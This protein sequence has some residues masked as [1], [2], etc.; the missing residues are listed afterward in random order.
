MI[1][2]VEI[3]NCLCDHDHAPFKGALS[4]LCLDLT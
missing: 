4:F 2:G 3:E 1:A